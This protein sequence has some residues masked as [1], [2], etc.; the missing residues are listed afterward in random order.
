MTRDI[1]ILLIE[2]EPGDVRLVRQLLSEASTREEQQT[3]D[4]TVAEQLDPALQFLE[5]S[6]IDLVLLDLSLAESGGLDTVQAALTSA[7]DAPLI[8][9]SGSEDHREA[10]A[11]VKAGA[12]DYLVKGA[13]TEFALSRAIHY[14]IE[15]K[16]SERSLRDSEAKFRRFVEQSEDAIVL[17]D[18][19]GRI[20]EWNRAAERIFGLGAGQAL[21]RPLWDVLYQLGPEEDK[22]HGVYE[23]LRARIVDTVRTG[24]QEVAGQLTERIIQWPDGAQRF[25]QTRAFPIKTGTGFL[26]G[27]ISRD[28]TERKQAEE[29]LRQSETLLRQIIRNSPN[30]IFVKDGRGRFVLANQA[31]ADL[32]GTTPE[33][34]RGRTNV[35]LATP[36]GL[37]VER[38]GELMADDLDVLAS[39]QPRFITKEHFTAADGT[40]RWFQT[41][42]IPMEVAGLSECLLVLATDITQRN[43]AEQELKQRTAQLEALRQVGLELSTELDLDRLLHS[44]VSRAMELMHGDAGGLYLYH[45]DRNVLEW[46]VRV[47]QGPPPLG[48]VRHRGEGLAGKVWDTGKALVEGRYRQGTGEKASSQGPAAE[49]RI[50]VPVRWGRE[51]MGVLQVSISADSAR[52]FDPAGTELL[53]M[54]ATQ[55][56]LAIHNARLYEASLRHNRELALLNRVIRAS[57]PGHEPKAVLEAMCRELAIAFDVPQAAAALFN[58]E[59]SAAVVVAEYRANGRPSG[60][61]AVIPATGNPSS[62]HLLQSKTP[63]V[64]DDAQSDP[65]LAAIRGLMQH[66]GTVSML[67]LP[68]AIDGE[69]VGSLGLDAVE[70]RPFSLEEVGLAQRVAEQTSAVLAHARLLETQSRLS[71]AVE[72]A[73]E[74]IIITDARGQIVYVNPA[75]E[76]IT[77]FDRHESAGQDLR[78][79]CDGEQQHCLHQ[80]LEEAIAAEQD[81]QGRVHGKKKDGGHFTGDAMVAPVRSRTG[82][83]VNYVTTIRDVTREVNLEEQFQKAQKLEALGRLAGGIAHD[84]NNLLTVIHLSTRLIE[85]QVPAQDPLRPHVE[86]IREAGQ[87]AANLT[88]QLLSFSRQ[89][90]MEPRLLDLNSIVGDM[91]SMLR[92][93]IGEDINLQTSLAEELWPVQA[94]P[95]QMEQVVMNLVVNARDAMPQGGTLKIQTAD[96]VID[97]IYAAQHVDVQPGEFV[98]L[99][100]SD[101]GVGMDGTVKA[102]IFE[103]FFTT[104]ERG[105]GTGLGLAT[106]F[107]I[108]KQHGGH[109]GVYSE[110]GQGTTF[111]IYLPHAAAGAATHQAPVP[112]ATM[113]STG[114]RGGTETILLVEDEE[115]VRNL[116]TSILQN[117]GYRVLAARNG[118]EALQS[119]AQQDGP[120]HLLLTDAVMPEMSGRELVR[121]LQ[122]QRPEIRVL[123]MSGHADEAIASHG[124]WPGGTPFLPKP[125][126]LEA[127]TTKVRAVLDG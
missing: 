107:G 55:A 46:A 77:G 111:Q 85:R 54:F 38:A 94:D 127:L 4:V 84:F 30:C 20:V 82:A 83:I 29:T 66:R 45:S 113:P 22:T 58:E 118:V 124:E 103:P 56:A 69:V 96:V 15:R 125:F 60:L 97:E 90:P 21:E 64:V 91:E 106:V 6:Q 19:Q 115:L 109:I 49:A 63:L 23:Q 2:D 36:L 70:Y 110:V 112:A 68:L 24:R 99:T 59:K 121:R 43:Q 71:T 67:L 5:Q 88:R 122:R 108:V 39:K 12:Q 35:E 18:E 10:L 44:I 16:Q 89:E 47:G 105:K 120:I 78:I 126:T 74:A 104:K 11:A 3:F 117:H 95:A 17:S 101:T 42:K 76:R 81:W 92:R 40:T 37:D 7:G 34:L 119:S 32:Y 100:I 116:A 87:H 50:G 52:R 93:I 98:R 28:L 102:R 57:V 27:S 31:F 114:I 13:L 73:A 86:R 75:C 48:Q 62:Q 72:Q 8:V 26:L 9:M 25:I 53:S 80:R 1:K 61:G 51:L 65:R 123:Y 79:L 14:A 41:A 33:A